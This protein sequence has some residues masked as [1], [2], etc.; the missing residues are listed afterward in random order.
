[1]LHKTA[2]HFSKFQKNVFL[3]RSTVQILLTQITYVIIKKKQMK[4]ADGC[5]KVKEKGGQEGAPAG[6]RC[7][8]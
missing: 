5:L 2:W 7:R 6:R 4:I 8:D 1:M 3:H